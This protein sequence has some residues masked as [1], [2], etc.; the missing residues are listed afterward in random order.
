MKV[1]VFDCESSFEHGIIRTM[2]LMKCEIGPNPV[3]HWVRKY[4]IADQYDYQMTDKNAQKFVRE[5]LEDAQSDEEIKGSFYDCL[6]DIM[7]ILKQNTSHVFMSFSIDN[8]IRFLYNTDHIQNTRYFKRHPYSYPEDIPIPIV[9]AQR[10]LTERCP[11][12]NRK[13]TGD[14]S[15]NSYI[16]SL[17]QRQQ[18]H[19]PVQDL[20]DL[21]DVLQMAW[22]LDQF[23]IPRTTYMYTKERMKTH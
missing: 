8:D 5:L 4:I 20:L 2:S 14:S 10:I 21:F 23:E 9:C 17:Y 12:T 1:L 3:I 15:L 22:N 6:C 18:T 19:R 16:Q 7:R 13:L 11:E